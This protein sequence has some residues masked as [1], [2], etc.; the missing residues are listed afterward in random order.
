MIRMAGTVILNRASSDAESPAAPSGQPPGAGERVEGLAQQRE[1][2]PQGHLPELGAD[3]ALGGFRLGRVAVE[4]GDRQA[5]RE[6]DEA[7]EGVP[8]PPGRCDRV[9]L[10]ERRLKPVV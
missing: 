5:A 4:N 2:I 8:E 6:R 9:L 10:V 1:P 3:D 7:L